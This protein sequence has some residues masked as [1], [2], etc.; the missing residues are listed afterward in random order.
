MQVIFT[1]TKIRKWRSR[2]KREILLSWQNIWNRIQITAHIIEKLAN[3]EEVF[4]GRAISPILFTFA[5][6]TNGNHATKLS[7]VGH[8]I[9]E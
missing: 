2:L 1:A 8:M 3:Q 9:S 7:T 4:G 6:Q 5:Y